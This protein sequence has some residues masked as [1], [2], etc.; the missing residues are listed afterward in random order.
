MFAL[1]GLTL[2]FLCAFFVLIVKREKE[3]IAEQYRK[4]IADRLANELKSS[5][6]KNGEKQEDEAGK[7]SYFIELVSINLTNLREYY[8]LVKKLYYIAYSVYCRLCTYSYFS[9]EAA[10]ISD[11]S[12][13]S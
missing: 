2:F 13:F 1:G 9:P 3:T 4:D 8:L 11:I 5:D 6:T 10:D 7:T 12:T